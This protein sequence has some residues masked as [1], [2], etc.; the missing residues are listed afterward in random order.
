MPEPVPPID[1]AELFPPDADP[2]AGESGAGNRVTTDIGASSKLMVTTM[3]L[4]IVLLL[5]RSSFMNKMSSPSVNKSVSCREKD[6]DHP[7]STIN[8]ISGPLQVIFSVLLPPSCPPRGCRAPSLEGRLF[9]LRR[10]RRARYL[11]GRHPRYLH[12]HR[13]PG[14]KSP[15]RLHRSVGR[16]VGRFRRPGRLPTA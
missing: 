12:R 10:R 16:D 1:A 13:H 3:L 9:L 7:A 4:Q 15:G 2:I 11:R 8:S 14:S 5:W 6:H